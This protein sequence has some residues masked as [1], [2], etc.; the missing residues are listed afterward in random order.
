MISSAMIVDGLSWWQSWL[1]VWFGY[2]LAATFIVLSARLGA[3]YH[4][5]FPVGIRASFGVWGS[6]WPILN[7]AVMACIWYGVQSWI[8]GMWEPSLRLVVDMLKA[9]DS[10]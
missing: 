4:V 9:A 1:C 10:F 5:S 8:G 6:L 2:L 7:R 3:V